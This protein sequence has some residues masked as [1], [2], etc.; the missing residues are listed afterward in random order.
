ME[1]DHMEEVKGF[2]MLADG[3]ERFTCP[4]ICA[5]LKRAEEAGFPLEAGSYVEQM[6][7]S[8]LAKITLRGEYDC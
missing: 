3:H 6:T 8:Q 2:Y 1:E 5:I 7:I 4:E